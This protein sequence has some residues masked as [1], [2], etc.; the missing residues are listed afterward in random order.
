MLKSNQTVFNMCCFVVHL[1]FTQSADVTSKDDL[2]VLLVQY[3]PS[4]VIAVLNGVVPLVF[5]IVVKGEDYSQP[6]VV[7]ITLI[8]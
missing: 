1:Q 5:G 8:R 2:T 3:S 4:I 6:M 7:K